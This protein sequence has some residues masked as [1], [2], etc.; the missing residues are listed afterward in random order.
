MFSEDAIIYVDADSLFFRPA[1]AISKDGLRRHWQKDL[2]MIIN[3]SIENIKRQCMSDNIRHAIK[4][5][6]NFRVILEPTYKAHRKKVEG[7][8]YEALSY[9]H[10]YMRSFHSACQADGMEADDLV[11]IWAHESMQKNQ[12]FTI[13]SIDK[14]LLQIPGNHYNFVSSTHR[15]VDHD[16]AHL[17]LMLQCLSGDQSDNIPGIRGI[18]PKKAKHILDG[19]PSAKRWDRV[20]AAWRSHGAGDPTHTWRLLKM[21]ESWEEYEEVKSQITGETPLSESDVYE[22]KKKEDR[23]LSRISARDSR[24]S[25][26]N[27]LAFQR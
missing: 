17:N 9:A 23:S 22:G 27:H 5:K 26:R 15:H 21:L 2:R 7:D 14:D 18:G 19:V 20:R 25:D 8:L 4:G 13:A 6:D 1:A 16:A 10:S 12:D 24:R 11:S 3:K